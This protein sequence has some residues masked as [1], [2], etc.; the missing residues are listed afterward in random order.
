MDRTRRFLKSLD[1][2]ILE[3][4]LASI[5]ILSSWYMSLYT[6]ALQIWSVYASLKDVRRIVVLTSPEKLYH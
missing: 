5:Y 2:A 1:I 3:I 4:W 6:R